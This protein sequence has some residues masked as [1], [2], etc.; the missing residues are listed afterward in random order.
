MIDG[1]AITCNSQETPRTSPSAEAERK[2][3]RTDSHCLLSRSQPAI[4][5]ELGAVLSMI[6]RVHVCQCCHGDDKRTCKAT[7]SDAPQLLED[8]IPFGMGFPA[9]NTSSV[10]LRHTLNVSPL[11]RSTS[12]MNE[13]KRDASCRA[14]YEI[15]KVFDFESIRAH[16]YSSSRKA[17]V[18]SG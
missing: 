5:Y 3:C 17:A 16:E 13:S 2:I 7:I 6:F 12:R 4:S 10:V 15:F 18:Y 14:P 8:N 9:T 1:G 11:V